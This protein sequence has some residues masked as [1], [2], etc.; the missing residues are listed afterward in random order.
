MRFVFISTFKIGF[1]YMSFFHSGN[2]D[3]K[4]DILEKLASVR[5]EL[6]RKHNKPMGNLQIIE[7]LLFCPGRPLHTNRRMKPLLPAK[8]FLWN[9]YISAGY[10]V[11]AA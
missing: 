3:K 7:A 11:D 1:H 5:S 2:D 6:T 10:V 8:Q 4:H 9:H